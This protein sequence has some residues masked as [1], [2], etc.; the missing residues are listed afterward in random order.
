MKRITLCVIAL[1]LAGCGGNYSNDDLAFLNALPH[2]EDLQSKLPET[3]SSQNGLQTRQ[4][5]LAVGDS[6]NIYRFTK[7]A[8]LKF[9]MGLEF[10]VGIVDAVRKYPPTTR[11]EDERVWGPYKDDQHPAWNVRMVMHREEDQFAWTIEFRQRTAADSDPWLKGIEGKFLATGGARKGKGELHLYAHDVRAAGLAGPDDDGKIAQLDATYVTDELPK[12]VD[13][14]FT[15]ETTSEWK[16]LDYSYREFEPGVA[17]MTFVAGGPNNGTLDIRSGWLKSG[18]G[19][20]NVVYTGTNG[21]SLQGFECWS[22]AY[23]VTAFNEPWKAFEPLGSGPT[24]GGNEADCVA[25]Q[26]I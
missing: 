8:S 25:P 16:S 12:T 5:E 9:N 21:S 23:N 14:Q 13:M 26:G 7:D 15:G 10:F 18:E 17:T 1:A 19:R 4:D 20:A 6:S 22:S 3:G 24:S 2:R 11:K